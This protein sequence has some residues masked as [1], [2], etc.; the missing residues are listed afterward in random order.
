MKQRAYLQCPLGHYSAG[1]AGCWFDYW[2]P[3]SLPGWWTNDGCAGRDGVTIADLVGAGLP[4]DLLPRT[5]LLDFGATESAF[6]GMIPLG[7]LGGS[8]REASIVDPWSP[9]FPEG[10]DCVDGTSPIL[11]FR[12]S[13]GHYFTGFDYCPLDGWRVDGIA[14]TRATFA[15]TISR[16]ELPRPGSIVAGPVRDELQPRVIVAQF[17]DPRRAVCGVAP[18]IY[19]HE[20]K[21]YL[22]RDSPE[23]FG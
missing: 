4:E 11:Y 23:P 12:C 17:G 7:F 18:M 13:G 16:G 21:T 22:D 19:H 15:E 10:V 3:Q 20:G 1:F 14:E 6:D 8:P 2:Q 5:I 9:A